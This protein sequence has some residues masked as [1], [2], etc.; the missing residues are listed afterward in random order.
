MV[1]TGVTWDSI[2]NKVNALKD[3]WLDLYM[4]GRYYKQFKKNGFEYDY[5][6]LGE[7]FENN[8]ASS[9]KRKQT[10]GSSRERHRMDSRLSRFAKLEASLNKWTEVM[11]IRKEAAIAKMERYKKQANETI[12]ST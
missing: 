8:T 11:D 5:D 3:V 2:S 6:I 7:I 4:K 12:V 1:R 9:D 10:F